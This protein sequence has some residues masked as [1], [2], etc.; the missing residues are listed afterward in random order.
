MC[1]EWKAA[2]EGVPLPLGKR[3][4]IVGGPGGL[5][6]NVNLQISERVLR[7]FHLAHFRNEMVIAKV[8]PSRIGS[9][10]LKNDR[11]LEMR[12]P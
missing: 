1:R 6:S 8:G 3:A 7:I 9:A 12:G 11:R 5:S 10:V 4:G 2:T